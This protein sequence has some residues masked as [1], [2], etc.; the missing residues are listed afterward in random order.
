MI[1]TGGSFNTHC[2]YTH[3]SSLVSTLDP[4]GKSAPIFL[5]QLKHTHIPDP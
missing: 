4:D 5:N 2:I 3:V 1:F